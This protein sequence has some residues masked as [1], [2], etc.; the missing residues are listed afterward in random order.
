MRLLLNLKPE[1]DFAYSS[2]QN[3]KMQGFIYNQLL[4]TPFEKLHDKSGY[5]FFCFSNVFIPNKNKEKREFS[6]TI[7]EN[8]ELNW[9]ISSPNPLFIETLK[10][11]LENKKNN[12]EKISIGETVFELNSIKQVQVKLNNDSKLITATPIIIRIPQ[13]AYANYN[14]TSNLPYLYWRPDIDFNAFIKQLE[15]NLYKKYEEYT[16]TKTERTPLFQIYKFNKPVITEII[17]EQKNIPVHGSIW[18]FTFNYLTTTQQKI[19]EF[20]TDTG[21]GEKNSL[22]YGFMNAV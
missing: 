9:L 15:E 8:Q 12:N 22:G 6:Q 21:L 11:K 16:G 20:G 5:K 18:E 3:H 14:V 17:E 1:S 10:Q 2:L 7:N 4:E 13:Y 19:I